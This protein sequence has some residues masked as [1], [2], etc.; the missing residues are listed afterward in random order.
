M[1][2][3][4]EI[5]SLNDYKVFLKLDL[6]KTDQDELITTLKSE[7]EA[8]VKER[9]KSDLFSQEYVEILDGT[10]TNYLIPINFPITAITKLEVYQGLDEN[11]EEVWYEWTKGLYYQRLF[12]VKG[13]QVFMDGVEFPEGNQNIRLTYT[14]G[15]DS[16]TLPL[17]IQKICKELMYLY[18]NETKYGHDLMGKSSDSQSS[19]GGTANTT[20]DLN[21]EDKILKRL[22][23]YGRIE[24]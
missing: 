23:S 20:Y 7:I 1:S 9:L 16:D 22:D 21:A 8:K 11:N 17:E 5:V 10:G 6:S 2:A 19:Q 12:I 24:F 18:W 14:A 13:V 3:L 4:T 15:Y